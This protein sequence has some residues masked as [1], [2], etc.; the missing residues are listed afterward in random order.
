MVARA[1]RSLFAALALCATAMFAHAVDEAELEAAIVY[2]VLL[3]A[4]WPHEVV[5]HATPLRLCVA[6]GG[7][8]ASAMKALQGRDLQGAPLETHDLLAAHATKPCHAV[9]VD[10]VSR[11]HLGQLLKVLRGGQVMSGSEVAADNQLGN[12]CGVRGRQ[13]FKA[14]QRHWLKFP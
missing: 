8:L 11:P 7:P 6:A 5:A 2:N 3:F 1:P 4:E 12:S 14:G 13:L 10:A 9:F